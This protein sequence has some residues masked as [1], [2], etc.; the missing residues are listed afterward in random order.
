MIQ[1]Q[2][3]IT[4]LQNQAA[5]NIKDDNVARQTQIKTEVK[6]KRDLDT[7]NPIP[8]K[9]RINT[10]TI[11]A[12]YTNSYQTTDA[13]GTPIIVA[14]KFP[15][16]GKEY[17]NHI[18]DITDRLNNMDS[19]EVFTGYQ[20]KAGTQKQQ[21]DQEFKSWVIRKGKDKSTWESDPSKTFTPERPYSE[22]ANEI[23]KNIETQ[24]YPG[25]YKF[26]IEK[27]HGRYSDGKPYKLNKIKPQK[28][29][30]GEQNLSNRMVFSAYIDNYNDSY[31]VSWN[32]YNF[33]GRA[34]GVPVYKGTKRDMTLEFTLLSDYSAEY[35]VAM[36]KFNEQLGKLKDERQEE[37]LQK[38]IKS[39]GPDWGLGEIRPPAIFEDGRVGG[40][41]PGMYSD[42]PEGLWSKITFLAQC[43]YPFYRTDG[44]M[45]EQPIIRMRIADFYD[46]IMYINNMSIQM[47]T[48]DGPMIDMNP[49]SLGNMPFGLKVTLSGVVQHNFEPS[50]DFYGFYNRKEYD[51][52]TYDP[53]T[54]VGI[55]L[56]QNKMQEGTTKNSPTEFNNS[57]INEKDLDI[58]KLD[59][60]KA[61]VLKQNV[62][63]FT[64]NFG[65]LKKSGTRLL[66]NFKKKKTKKSIE[67][68]NA[69]NDIVNHFRV[70]QGL[71]PINSSAG[72]ALN[73]ANT[74]D[75]L[76]KGNIVKAIQNQKQ[77][78]DSLKSDTQDFKKQFDQT[79]GAIQNTAQEAATQL[80]NINNDL[81]R[82]GINVTND[83]EIN[84]IVEKVNSVTP[85]Q[86]IPKTLGDIISRNKK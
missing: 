63:Q 55:N 24:N 26:F 78:F 79:Y 77:K 60:N 70:L 64:D 20:G 13:S 73:P 18:K 76:K 56:H 23:L 16:Q 32:E 14:T 2:Y 35:M 42:T 3:A 62:T 84:K 15:E 7:N 81:K 51:N 22:Y 41:I 46:V 17:N 53:V 25:S 37:L 5:V 75:D 6:Q 72:G 30:L 31:A 38:L 21:L 10:R 33:L 39:A 4:A 11:Q 54:G 48:F 50:S 8:E 61:G 36:E 49:S 44:K 80:S 28:T 83:P 82:I 47:T 34:E 58:N 29:V 9:D 40:H 45:K 57:F 59:F 74:K 86:I 71:E 85:S 66:D 43:C 27:L 19:F 67:A 69:V 65:E 52:G 68:F 1:Q 12:G